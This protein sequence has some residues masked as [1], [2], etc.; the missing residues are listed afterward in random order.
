MVKSLYISV[1]S[2]LHSSDTDSLLHGVATLTTTT[3]GRSVT[4]RS[5][6]GPAKKNHE[7]KETPRMGTFCK[8]LHMSGTPAFLCTN[9][10][11][12]VSRVRRRERRGARAAYYEP[13][14]TRSSLD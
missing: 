6:I 5:K 10:P 2:G 1:S 3:R 11:A 13:D 4:S 14:G 12:V 9:E 8:T 7:G